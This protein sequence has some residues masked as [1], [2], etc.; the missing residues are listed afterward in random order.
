VIFLIIHFSLILR[1][2]L[3]FQLLKNNTTPGKVYRYWALSGYNF[4]KGGFLNAWL[5]REEWTLLPAGLLE[6]AVG[7]PCGAVLPCRGNGKLLR[8]VF[9]SDGA[10]HGGWR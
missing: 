7:M 1:I 4:P 6:G 9:Y 10:M 3:D 8:L 2:I 5:L